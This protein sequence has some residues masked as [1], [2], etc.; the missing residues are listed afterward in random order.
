MTFSHSSRAFAFAAMAVLTFGSVP[1]AHAAESQAVVLKEADTVEAEFR[2]GAAGKIGLAFKFADGKT[3]TLLGAVKPDAWKRTVEKDG[4]KV[5]ELT[6]MPEGAIEFSGPGLKFQ[7]HS[8]PFLQRYTEGQQADLA[9]VWETL[10]AAS[11][12]WVALQVRADAAGA[13]LWMDGRYCGRLASESRL[14]EVSFTQEAGGE[15]RGA[16]VFTRADHGQFL[17]LD[18]RRIAR[19]GVMKEAI[20]TRQ[21]MLQHIRGV[22]ILV[23][24]GAS[25]ADVGMAKEMQGLR[26][27]ET[28]ENT[29]RTSLDGMPESLHFSVPQA[30]YYRAWVLCAVESDARKDPVLTTR[31]TRFGQWGRGGAMA[32]TTLT[33]PRPDQKAAEGMEQVGRVEYTAARQK[34]STPLYLVRVDLKTGDILDILADQ[35]DP[36]AAMKIGPYL[37][38]EFLGKCGGLEVQTDRRRKPAPTSTSAVHI[39]G[40]TLEKAPVELRLKQAQPGN[41]FHNDETPE[42]TFLVRTNMAGRYELRWQITGIDGRELAEQARPVEL[43]VVGSEAEMTVSLAMPDLGWYGLHVTLVD[44]AGH[45]VCTHQAAFALLGKDTRTA[46]YE[47]PFGTW[48]FNGVHY[49]TKDVAEAGPMLFKAGFRRTT[50]GWTKAT[51][52]DFT[53]WKFSLNQIN[54]SF[55]LV[56]LKDWPAAEARA[57]KTIGDLLKRFPHCQYIDVFH[58]SYDPGAYPPELSGEKYVAK[59]AALAAR[60]DELFELGV[61]AA[62]FIRAKF[63][64]LKIIAGNSGG[65]AGIVAL[66]VRRGFPREL[67][68]YL[69]S[70]T[71]GQTIAPEKLSPHTTGGIW[72]M[73]ETARQYGYDVPLS[74]CYEFTCRAERDLGAQRHAE[75]YARDVLMGLANRF[76]TVSPAVIEDV[77]NA[78][79]DTLWGAS[80]L[81]QRQPLHYPKPAYVALATLTKVLDRVQL[82]QQMPTGSSSAHAVEF[83]RGQEHIYALWTPRGQ[84]EMEFEFPSETAVTQVEFYGR[85]LPLKTKGQRFTITADTAVSYVMSPLAA[86]RITAGRR[87]FPNHQPPAGT[88]VISKMDDLAQWQLAPADPTLTTPLRRPGKFELRQVNDAERGAC[89]ELELK[90]EGEIRAVVGEYTALRVPQ[91]LPIPDRPHTVGVWVKGDSSWG[92]IYWELEDAK[93]ERWRSSKDLDG[94]DWGNQSALDFDG[95]CFVTFPLTR[96]SPALQIEPGAGH[97]QWQGN[98]DGQLDYPLKLVGLVVQTHRQSLDLTRMQPVKGAIRLKDVSAIGDAP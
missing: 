31:L 5:P 24:D 30:Y 94:G 13:E 58:E 36:Y 1:L 70:E 76:P 66:M 3:Q 52:E 89:L 17:P 91:P 16:R 98:G 29:S 74:G 93:G 83:A 81:C 2:V 79:Y 77:G 39:F 60:E 41:I 51:E 44:A 9:N 37:D 92:R 69:G 23:A 43:S 20:V 59:D 7:Y 84:C 6:P 12:C 28:N 11:Q 64:E 48:W 47:S 10:P 38:F 8:R 21:P 14:K 82:V 53:P 78:Y 86:T 42:T 96:E 73:A 49:S 80:G 95:W 75:W 19:P 65:S 33:L 4:R 63:P 40:V 18:V 34:I 97:G 26:A 68:D 15:V 27:L 72:L 22:P 25:N 62:R 50:M 54:W 45:A 85:Q 55:R 46:G 35:K 56:D 32:D 87:A 57:G 90:H 61:K 71:T 88:S 67:I